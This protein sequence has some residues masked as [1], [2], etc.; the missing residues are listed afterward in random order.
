[1]DPNWALAPSEIAL[2]DDGM[3]NIDD[4]WDA[5]D[6]DEDDPSA[7]APATA[8][9][10]VEPE[11]AKPSRV[12]DNKRPVESAQLPQ[13]Q[14]ITEAQISE[15]AAALPERRLH[16]ADEPIKL[17]SAASPAA[18]SAAANKTVLISDGLLIEESEVPHE[19]VSAQKSS[20]TVAAEEDKSE[21]QQQHSKPGEQSVLDEQSP[22]AADPPKGQAKGS[23]KRSRKSQTLVSEEPAEDMH[24]AQ[25]PEVPKKAAVS[26]PGSRKRGRKPKAVISE[27]AEL[28]HV[29]IQPAAT[30]SRAPTKKRPKSSSAPSPSNDNG[31]ESLEA[32]VPAKRATT[33]KQQRKTGAALKPDSL[34]TSRTAAVV[35]GEQEGAAAAVGEAHRDEYESD[36]SE[37]SEDALGMDLPPSM[38]DTE[39]VVAPPRKR[40]RKAKPAAAKQPS[41]AAKP[42]VKHPVKAVVASDAEEE[43][44]SEQPVQQAVAVDEDNE[45]VGNGEQTSEAVEEAVIAE[46]AVVE[47]ATMV[48]TPARA[49][50]K[51]KRRSMSSMNVDD[52]LFSL[53]NPG[54]AAGSKSSAAAAAAAA[55]KKRAA[56]GPSPGGQQA[57]KEGNGKRRL[58]KQPDADLLMEAEPPELAGESPSAF[59]NLMLRPKSQSRGQKPKKQSIK[60]QPATQQQ[61]DS[62]SDFDD[63]G[64]DGGID[65]MELLPADAAT[66]SNKS[67][68]ADKTA[69]GVAAA[70]QI[71][72]I[73]KITTPEEVP[74]SAR[75]G[76]R[77]RVKPLEFWNN[78]MPIYTAEGSLEQ[79]Q[80]VESLDPSPLLKGRQ[81]AASQKGVSKLRRTSGGKQSSRQRTPKAHRIEK[82][83]LNTPNVESPEQSDND[84]NDVEPLSPQMLHNLESE[85]FRRE[86]QPMAIVKDALSGEDTTIPIVK[87]AQMLEFVMCQDDSLIATAFEGCDWRCGVLLIP[88]QARTAAVSSEDKTQVCVVLSGQIQVSIHKSHFVLAMGGQFFVP[89][90]NIFAIRNLSHSRDCRVCLTGFTTIASDLPSAGLRDPSNGPGSETTKPTDSTKAGQSDGAPSNAAD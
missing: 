37:E 57:A 35:A 22:A 43:D 72:R 66:P 16:R 50:N 75:R 52:I 14:K 15:E 33:S 20:V 47:K 78:E 71:N 53:S 6:N 40:I 42:A 51:V 62:G 79:V 65:A 63:D 90:H 13:R 27:E 24:N 60:R 83:S 56:T 19:R 46:Q 76:Q 18:K 86:A 25:L 59:D 74:G 36:E 39:P 54:S 67:S 61:N 49:P 73:V 70:A 58:Y 55:N 81:G 29:D 28:D 77:K 64:S 1:M 8:D 5:M 10:V 9:P 84:D 30:A 41:P 7:A 44:N 23:S 34:V 31:S 80:Q 21:P 82:L 88:P 89:P 68:K 3:E 69:S 17:K 38:V 12:V 26:K 45:G 48:A 85:G 4:F 11:Q 87:S 2:D 32:E